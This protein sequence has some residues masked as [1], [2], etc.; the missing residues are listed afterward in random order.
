MKPIIGEINYPEMSQ[1]E[2]SRFMREAEVLRA[3]AV[4]GMFKA[5]FRG[6]AFVAHRVAQGVRAVA[7][8]PGVFPTPGTR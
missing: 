7:A 3:E 1:E 6:V 8:N 5:V 2:I 4:R